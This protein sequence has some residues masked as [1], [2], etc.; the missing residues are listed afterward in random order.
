MNVVVPEQP[1]VPTQVPENTIRGYNANGKNICP[2]EQTPAAQGQEQLR[3]R[4]RST[5]I[6]GSLEK[7]VSEL[8]SSRGGD[9]KSLDSVGCRRQMH[10]QIWAASRTQALSCVWKCGLI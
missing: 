8:A 4:T 6:A 10:S 7:V 5:S 1:R 3:C 2:H 9:R